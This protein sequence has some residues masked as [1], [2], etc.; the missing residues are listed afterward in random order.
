MLART[1]RKTLFLVLGSAF[2]LLLL[3]ANPAIAREIPNKS[4]LKEN[5]EVALKG[6]ERYSNAQHGFS[7]DYPKTWEKIEPKDSLIICKFITLDGLASYRVVVEKLPSPITLAEYYK[8][9]SD[10]IKTALPAQHMAVNFVS[11]GDSKL[12][13][14]PAKKTIYTLAFEDTPRT[15]KIEQYLAIKGDK[16]FVFNYTAEEPIFDDFRKVIDKAL[17]SMEFQ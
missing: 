16:G 2:Q 12:G 4:E 1:S 8:L 15:A 7:I 3:A 9:T 5:V 14:V 6:M 17:D 11:E 13:G 10:Q